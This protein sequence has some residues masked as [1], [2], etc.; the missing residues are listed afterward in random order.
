MKR[1][2][3]TLLATTAFGLAAC[4]PNV[5]AITPMLDLGPDPRGLDH[6]VLPFDRLARATVGE[7]VDRHV[8][9]LLLR[10]LSELAGQGRAHAR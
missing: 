5:V 10:A 4:S 7:D 8:R 6:G 3:C 1:T 9:L 2:V